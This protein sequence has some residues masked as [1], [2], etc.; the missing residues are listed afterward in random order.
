[1]AESEI[2]LQRYNEAAEHIICAL[3]EEHFEDLATDLLAD[4]NE[5]LTTELMPH[6]NIQINKNPNSVEWHMYKLYLYRNAK[7]YEQAIE[8]AEKIKE[9]DANPY[10]DAIISSLYE[11]MGDFSS[12]LHYAQLAYQADST[13]ADYIT[14]LASAYEN[15]DS[16]QQYL[17]LM[18]LYVEQLPESGMAYHMRAQYYFHTGNYQ[19]AIDDY[20]TAITLDAQDTFGRYMRGRAYYILGDTLKA[21]RDLQRVLDDSDN[22]VS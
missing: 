20:T 13:E 15:V 10:F 3:K 8:C 17:D 19:S 11:Q 4:A 9:L 12:A 5:E 14:T 1:M 2:A 16:L 7:N 6:L 21:N 18:E 22:D